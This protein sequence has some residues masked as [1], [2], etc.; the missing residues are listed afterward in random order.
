VSKNVATQRCNWV[1]RRILRSAKGSRSL[2]RK[3]A[4]WKI[5]EGTPHRQGKLALSVKRGEGKE[6]L[7]EFS[8]SFNRKG[9]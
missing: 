3:Q 8:A 1:K 6:N 5:S 7:E 2:C 9:V 4:T